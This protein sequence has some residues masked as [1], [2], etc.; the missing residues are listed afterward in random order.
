MKD[1]NHSDVQTWFNTIW[2]ALHKGTYGDREWDDICTA[3][4]WLKEVVEAP[5]EV[6]E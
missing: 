3:M 1:L 5:E 4:A 2:N 6:D